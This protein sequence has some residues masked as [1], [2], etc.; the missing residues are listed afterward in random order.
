MLV[1]VSGFILSVARLKGDSS[2]NAFYEHHKNNI[3]FHYRCFDRIMLNAI[4][5]PFQQEQRVVG[6]F[7]TYRQLYPVTRDVLRD[8]STQFHNWVQN[9]SQRWNAPTVDDPG[10]RRHKFLDP[11]FKH[12]KPDQVVCTRKSR[13]PSRITNAF[14]QC[15]D[16]EALQRFADSLTA[17]DLQHCSQK[18]LAQL[19]PFFTPRERREAGVQHRLFFFEAEYCDNLVFRRRAALDRL[20]QRLLDANRTI[21]QPNKLTVIFGRKI[22]KLYRGQL[23]I[24]RGQLLKL[25]QP[26]VYPNGK[27]IP[28]LKLD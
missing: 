9:R 7:N 2:M 3:R 28:G 16:P 8:I 26:T 27:R 11:Y 6:F 23:H 25:T 22:S 20:C 10:V 21:G 13:A 19:T 4:I 5:Q 14:S 17:N 15:S 12:A 1:G 18:W 24:D